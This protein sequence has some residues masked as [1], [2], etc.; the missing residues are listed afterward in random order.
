[1]INV[2][3]SSIQLSINMQGSFNSKLDS[4]SNTCTKKITLGPHFISN[5]LKDSKPAYSLRV[6]KSHQKPYEYKRLSDNMKLHLHVKQYVADYLGVD[7]GGN[8]NCF[9]WTLI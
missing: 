2:S 9:D 5:A 3:E 7:F 4:L 8:V 6:L 1:M